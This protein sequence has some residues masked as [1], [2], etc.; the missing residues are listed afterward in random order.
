MLS[1]R[2]RVN[3]RHF[4]LLKAVVAGEA[5]PRASKEMLELVDWGYVFYDGGAFVV[6]EE[7]AKINDTWQNMKDAGEHE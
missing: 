7:G 4:S 2:P 5:R 1:S 3:G 6:T